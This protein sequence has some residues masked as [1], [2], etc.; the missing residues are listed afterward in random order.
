VEAAVSSAA[1][2]CYEAGCPESD[3]NAVDDIHASTRPVVLLR[4]CDSA[5]TEVRQPAAER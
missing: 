2:T 5:T 1:A 4:M 3:V